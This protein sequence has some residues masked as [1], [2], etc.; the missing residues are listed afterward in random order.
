[1]ARAS[2]MGEA[3]PVTITAQPGPPS[4]DA[5][6]TS[7]GYR[8]DPERWGALSPV[9]ESE[10]CD[11][12]TLWERLQRDGYLFLPGLLDRDQVLAFRRYFFAALG[13]AGV[14][15]PDADPMLGRDS[16]RPVDRQKLRT[17]LFEHVVPGPEYE[18]FCTQPALWNWF[19]W[20]F[21]DEVFLHK[22]RILRHTRPGEMGIGTATQAHYDLLYLREGTDRL[23]SVWIPLGDIPIER[24]PLIYLEGTHVDYLGAEQRGESLPAASMTA[25]LPG[26]A[27][28]KDRRWLGTDFR[29]GDVM[30]HSPYMVH[31]SLDNAD[32]DGI[33]RLSTDIRYQ[34]RGDPI[35]WR[36]QNYW[37]DRDGL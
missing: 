28:A 31:A 19:G 9:P 7:N 35:D 23:L 16:G 20:M 27:E 15:D 3:G 12:A 30:I 26:L 14:T 13:E 33:M 36:W 17:A 18:A 10:R 1:M 34:R 5:A 25:D 2:S 37:H 8:L 11:R 32:P 4:S 6:L 24:G 21:A 29:A 22:R